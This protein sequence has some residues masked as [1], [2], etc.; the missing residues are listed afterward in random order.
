MEPKRP[1]TL[2]KYRKSIGITAR[3]LGRKLGMYPN[4]ITRLEYGTE[5][6][7]ELTARRFGEF[8]GSDW[9]QFLSEKYHD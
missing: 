4:H 8:F 9:K 3:E 5:T 2:R 1:S 7:G 6:C